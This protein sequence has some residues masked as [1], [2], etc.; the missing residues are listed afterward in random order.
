M[1]AAVGGSLMSKS[2]DAANELLEEMAL[3][4]SHWGNQR[5][6]PKKIPGKLEVD[7]WTSVKAQLATLQN[8]MSKMSAGPSN[9]QVA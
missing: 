3:N 7:E 6:V 1:D 2:M 4:N 8:Q 5:Q 9:V